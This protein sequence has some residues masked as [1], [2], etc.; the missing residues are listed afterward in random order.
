MEQQDTKLR[1]IDLRMF[2]AVKLKDFATQCCNVDIISWDILGGITNDLG[3]HS[4]NWNL[5]F[6][7][8]SIWRNRPSFVALGSICMANCSFVRVMDGVG[9]ILKFAKEDERF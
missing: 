3:W 8:C 4:L 5:T 2:T 1:R 7:P 6:G 9:N